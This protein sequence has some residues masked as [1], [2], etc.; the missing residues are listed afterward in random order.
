MLIDICIAFNEDYQEEATGFVRKGISFYEQLIKLIDSIRKNWDKSVYDYRIYVFHSRDLE[1]NHYEILKREADAL[2]FDKTDLNW[3]Q[4]KGHI[5]KYNMHGD[6]TLALDTD[7]LFLRT[8][9]FSFDK[10]VYG[11]PGSM[12]SLKQRHWDVAHKLINKK[13]SPSKNAIAL[14]RQGK[15]FV[16]NGVN[17]GCILIKNSIK[18]AFFRALSDLQPKIFQIKKR[19]HFL[20]QIT[21]S[22]AMKMFDYGYFPPGINYFKYDKA[23]DLD[24][25][26][27]SVL[28]YLA[29]TDR[30][31][32]IQKIIQNY[33]TTNGA[34]I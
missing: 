15:P 24:L 29:K 26:K 22:I 13:V 8:P 10:E 3:T 12:M 1:R 2:I 16:S 5:F 28:H 34:T 9:Q 25:K 23:D 33:G 6:Y 19:E 11:S 32:Q 27:V 21:L 17:D 4:N 20:G 31:P 14:H 18:T 30:D 7:I